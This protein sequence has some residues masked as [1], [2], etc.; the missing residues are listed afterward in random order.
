MKSM[1]A[2][3]C[4]HC[5]CGT[6]CSRKI[7]GKEIRFP[8]QGP[9]EAVFPGQFSSTK[10]VSGFGSGQKTSPDKIMNHAPHIARIAARILWPAADIFPHVSES[11]QCWTLFLAGYALHVLKRASLSA[12]SKLSG[13]RSRVEWMRTNA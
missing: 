11:A 4:A 3:K 6:C 7:E 2:A 5:K 9:K 13:T 12:Q 1:R 8:S 10:N